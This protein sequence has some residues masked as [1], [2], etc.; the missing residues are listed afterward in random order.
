MKFAFVV[1]PLSE[2]SKALWQMD[3][4]GQLLSHWENGNLLEICDFV[5]GRMA[6]GVAFGGRAKDRP[7]VLDQF[8]GL[9]TKTGCETE[10]RVYE[11]PCSPKQILEDPGTAIEQTQAAV[12]MAADWG[13]GIVGLGSLTSV[14]GGHGQ[15]IAENSPIPVTTGNSL[16]VYAALKN[17]QHACSELSIDLTKETVTV[18][19][20]PGSIATAIARMLRTK[21][22][23]MI[24]V[25]R[26]PS[27]RATRIAAELQ[28][29]L[30]FEIPTALAKSRLILSATSSGSCIVQEMLQAGSV[31]I[32]VGV[33]A[34]VTRS[35]RRRSN[36]LVVSGG[37]VDVP[38]GFLGKSM[39]LGFHF[40]L[41]PGCLAETINLALED[42]AESFSLGRDLSIERIGEIGSIATRHGFS[43]SQ[44]SS[45]GRPVPDSLWASMNKVVGRRLAEKNFA[46]GQHCSATTGERIAGS[47]TNG[48][49]AYGQAQTDTQRPTDQKSKQRIQQEEEIKN[50]RARTLFQRYVN[51]VLVNLAEQGGLNK[52]FVRGQDTVIT[53]ADENHYLDFVS[54]FG[55]LNVGHNHPRVVEAISAALE[56]SVPGFSPAAINPHAASLSERLVSIAPAGL[57]MVFFCNSGTEAVESALK[58]ARATTGRTGIIYCHGSYHGKSLGALSVTGN[59]GYQQPFA[60]LL[61]DCHPIPY[62]NLEVLERTLASR[63]MA[64]F[65]VEPIQGEGGMI[66]PPAGYLAE[67]ERICRQ[68]GTLLIADEVQTGMGR[69][70]TMFASEQ[71]AIEPDILCVAK[72]LS[73][74]LVPIGAML[75]RRDL[76]MKAYGTVERFALHTSTFGGGSLACIA[77]LA[78]I[79]TLVEE[80]LAENA[81]QRGFQI[82]EGLNEIRQELPDYFQDIRGQ[83]LMIGVELSPLAESV[84]THLKRTDSTG[85]LQYMMRGMDAMIASFP[86][87]FQ[88]QILLEHYHIYTQVTRSNPLVLRIQPPLTIDASKAAHF[89]SSFTRTCRLGHKVENLF[90]EVITRSISGQHIANSEAGM[91]EE[92]SHSSTPP[93]AAS[94]VEIDEQ[95]SR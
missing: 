62:G 30:V 45:Y 2:E 82:L 67:A 4:G 35:T 27:P 93:I 89:I 64:A 78:T 38:R 54:G 37:L 21:V 36:V 39:L 49:P 8:S 91:R 55:S 44:L 88:M 43:F 65:I 42:R 95:C 72:S 71:A 1:H 74:G 26:R 84:T 20:L 56:S 50:R 40:G 73:G 41:V 25:A 70:G 53:D 22:G 12:D 33:P 31:V 23:E 80:R 57:E 34:D 7:I 83:G 60:P 85:M 66:L 94:G 75:A 68:A 6:E 5:Q 86:T 13:A 10:G 24:L 92:R 52:T 63:N 76:W 18:I 28:S 14:V 19:G 11:I 51:P 90:E 58:L 81:A 46:T 59:R 3:D 79:E 61:P 77:G 87:V 15:Y 32:D 47:A 17:L 29:E 9:Q 16:T 69:T 48:H